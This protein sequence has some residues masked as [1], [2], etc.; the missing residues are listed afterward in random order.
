MKVYLFY[1][2]KEN[3]KRVEP[4]LYAY[5][6]KKIHKDTF[7]KTR[8]MEIFYMK[9]EKMKKFDFTRFQDIHQGKLLSDFSFITR[10]DEFPTDSQ[11][12]HV[13]A[14]IR[15]GM[16]THQISDSFFNLISREGIHD[17]VYALKKKYKKILSDMSYFSIMN[18][19]GYDELPFLP[20]EQPK[21][22]E[23]DLFN[24]KKIIIDEF[25][26][27]LQCFGDTMR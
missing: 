15:E 1:R 22:L 20:I 19:Y 18:W 7:L 13:V 12:I 9:E 3:Q 26:Y 14:T 11:H 16:Q 25:Q 10:I 24:D 5:T 8:N 27:F 2:F 21:S 17:G 4:Y 6:E 23:Y